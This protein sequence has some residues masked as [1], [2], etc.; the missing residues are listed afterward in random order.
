MAARPLLDEHLLR[1]HVPRHLHLDGDARRGPRDGRRRLHVDAPCAPSDPDARDARQGPKDGQHLR[2]AARRG[3][4][5]R[6]LCDAR[7]AAR[8]GGPRHRHADAEE[9]P[10]HAE[11]VP[12]RGG[13]ARRQG[14]RRRRDSPGAEPGAL[15]TLPRPPERVVGARR[16]LAHR[17]LVLHV[18]LAHFR[19]LVLYVPHLHRAPLHL[20]RVH[21]NGLLRRRPSRCSHPRH[22][23]QASGGW[24][25]HVLA[26]G[27]GCAIHSLPVR[28]GHDHRLQ[29]LDPVARLDWHHLHLGLGVLHHRARLRVASVRPRS[30]MCADA[31]AR[32]GAGEALVA[33]G[34]AL[35]AGIRGHRL[36]GG[37]AEAVR[38]AVPP[39][40]DEGRQ[41]QD[42]LRGPG[43]ARPGR[44]ASDDRV[45]VVPRRPHHDDLH[46]GAHHYRQG[47]RAGQRRALVVEAGE[48]HGALAV[49]H[50]AVDVALDPEGRARRDVPRRRL[51]PPP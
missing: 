28:R 46:V 35:A 8:G 47:L 37:G 2:A 1:A 31:G 20:A 6:A 13:A 42:G 45:E 39:A 24:Q 49:P 44:A 17:R 9:R 41:G 34:V 25:R 26:G 7:A 19:Q 16:V 48:P 27:E 29:H 3:R 15:R 30:T 18:P 12:R 10:P 14:R 38:A 4:V 50:A 40:G 5:P 33:A 23:P 22:R 32:G 11:V 36:H 21:R 43:E 51:R